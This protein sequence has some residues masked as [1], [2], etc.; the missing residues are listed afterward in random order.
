MEGA[1]TSLR[2]SSPIPVVEAA[3]PLRRVLRPTE[4]SSAGA[5]S[6][7]IKLESRK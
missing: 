6:T 3:C 1:S 2:V 4:Y 7:R 5:W